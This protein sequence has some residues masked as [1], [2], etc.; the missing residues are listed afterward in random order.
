M[1]LRYLIGHNTSAGPLLIGQ[2]AD[3][4]F[5]P[6]WKGESLGPYSSLVG[7][8]EDAAGGHTFTPSDGTDL[9]SLGLSSDPA[10]WLPASLLM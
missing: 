9:G 1:K 5:H 8:I 4:K 7:A 10:D 6:I 2:T 3:G